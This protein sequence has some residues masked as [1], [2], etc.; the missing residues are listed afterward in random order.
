MGNCP[1]CSPDSTIKN[2]DP[3]CYDERLWPIF[4]LVSF[5][6]LIIGWIILILFY[7]C[8]F[9][10]RRWKMLRQSSANQIV[11]IHDDSHLLEDIK[12]WGNNVIS[13]QTKMGKT[14]VRI[15]LDLIETLRH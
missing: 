1:T 15:H 4:L 6:I 13:G 3:K 11:D 8:Q 12:E 10:S 5:G 2:L 7:S 14:C 9:A